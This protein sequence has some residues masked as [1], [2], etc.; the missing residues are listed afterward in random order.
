[1]W[2]LRTLLKLTEITNCQN[3]RPMCHLQITKSWGC[4]HSFP[5]NKGDNRELEQ[6]NKVKI[7]I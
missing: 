5:K 3:S 4:M 7:Q 2:L 1:M 6:V